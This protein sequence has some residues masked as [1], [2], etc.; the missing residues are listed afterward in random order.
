MTENLRVDYK[1]LKSIEADLVWIKKD[2]EHHTRAQDDM[3][4][5]Y[6]AKT[7]A[8]A[9]DDFTDNWTRNRKQFLEQVEKLGKWVN[10]CYTSCYQLD[11]KLAKECTGK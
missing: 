1:T 3:R 2:F 4:G 7:V 6:G 5:I 10:H 9:M 8:D 11:V